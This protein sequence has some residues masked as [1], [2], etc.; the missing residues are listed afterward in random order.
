MAYD[1]EEQE[2]LDEFKAWWNKNGKTVTSLLVA[3]LLAYASW[4]GYQ[5]WTHQ[6]ATKASDLYQTL[7]TTEVNKTDEIQSQAQHITQQFSRTPYAG[8]AAVYAAKVS[9]EAK[10]IDQAKSQL[11]WAK[12]NAR[13]SSVQAIAAL[14]LASIA[15]E[16]QEYDVA[17]KLLN[18]IQ[19]AGF[20]GL[21]D[22]LLGDILL[23]QGKTDEAKKAYERALENLD[24]QERYHAFTK[25]KLESLGG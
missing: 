5:Y 1:L 14:Q 20:F 24:K 11:E 23:A 17:V 3:S 4:Q 13:E 12:N 18:S 8:R 16:N 6:Q 10:E 22:S 19:D 15:F 7:L 21:K 2:Q 25:L 9:Y